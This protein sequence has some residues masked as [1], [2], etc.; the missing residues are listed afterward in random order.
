MKNSCEDSLVMSNEG[1][2]TTNPRSC[3]GKRRLCGERSIESMPNTNASL[4]YELSVDPFQFSFI[5]SMSS[6]LN[7]CDFGNHS[8]SDVGGVNRN[9]C[10]AIPIAYAK[11]H[12]MHAYAPSLCPPYLV[13]IIAANRLLKNFSE[14]VSLFTCAC[15]SSA[16]ALGSRV[17]PSSSFPK[18]LGYHIL[19][20]QSFSLCSVST[21]FVRG[22]LAP[23]RPVGP[24][25]PCDPLE[26]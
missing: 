2:Y 10:V 3:A 1:S 8:S 26:Q 9:A 21:S 11:Q 13:V 20:H 6:A 22:S 7:M 17:T 24:H 15:S 18:H 25:V 5:L 16:L 4:M 19:K 14:Y 23:Q 12:K